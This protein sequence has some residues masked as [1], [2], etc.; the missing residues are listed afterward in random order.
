MVLGSITTF[1]PAFDTRSAFLAVPPPP[2]QTSASR[3]AFAA[4]SRTAGIM[5]FTSPSTSIRCGL[6]RLVPRIVPP[7]VRIPA[8]AR[9]SILTRRSSAR[10]RNP[11]RNPTTSM[12][13]PMAALPK[14]R[15]AALRP[16]LSPP[17]VMIPTRRG[18]G[19]A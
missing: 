1:S 6:S 2:R 17:A 13:Y 7:T 11:S 12:P 5:S 19:M 14:P 4:V 15:M 10:P 3:F 16:G 18:E 9:V 8:S